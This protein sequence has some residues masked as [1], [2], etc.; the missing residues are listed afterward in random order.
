MSARGMHEDTAANMGT[1]ADGGAV[2]SSNEDS[3]R[4]NILLEQQFLTRAYQIHDWRGVGVEAATI[5]IRL[6]VMNAMK[7]RLSLVAASCT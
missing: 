4:I 3:P 2:T 5:Y 7:S 6:L 1:C